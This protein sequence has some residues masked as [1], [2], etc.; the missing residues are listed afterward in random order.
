MNILTRQEWEAEW[1]KIEVCPNENMTEYALRCM[2]VKA[3]WEIPFR[4]SS[5]ARYEVYIEELLQAGIEVQDI[6]IAQ[7]DLDANRCYDVPLVGKRQVELTG[8]DS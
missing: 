2:Q 1:A 8:F 6:I 4:F 5:N 3:T 7:I